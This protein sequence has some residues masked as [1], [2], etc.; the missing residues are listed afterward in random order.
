MPSMD[1]P[2]IAPRWAE[3]RQ[4]PVMCAVLR[5]SGRV[6]HT[7]EHRHVRGQL[8]GTETG[9]LTVQAAR[10]RWIVPASM[11]LVVRLRTPR[12]Y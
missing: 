1:D 3:A 11:C 9:L 6:R 10:H 2:L 7:R 4:G 12:R 8:L 5:R